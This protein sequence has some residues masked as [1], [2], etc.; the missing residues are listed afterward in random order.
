MSIDLIN[1]ALI[2]LIQFWYKEM[3]LL[4]R[5]SL[6]KI[7]L[8]EL[9]KE[10]GHRLSTLQSNAEAELINRIHQAGTEKIDFILFNPAAFTHTS[11]A[12]RDALLGVK[13]P[14]IEIHLSNVHAREDFRKFSHVSG[15]SVGSIFGL[16]LKG[17]ELAV[18]WFIDNA[19]NKF[20]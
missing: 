4:L 17:Y 15:K 7:R 11:I 13:I 8:E 5:I 18:K 1:S 14:F 19:G 2:P 3:V 12:L 6:L 20:K 10:A 9:A 16:G